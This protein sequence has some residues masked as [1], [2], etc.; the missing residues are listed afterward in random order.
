MTIVLYRKPGSKAV[1]SFWARGASGILR[2]VRWQLASLV[3][4]VACTPRPANPLAP[5][6][7]S[8]LEDS[9]ETP[10]PS[11]PAGAP[12]KQ[13][14]APVTLAEHAGLRLV[15][16]RRGRDFAVAPGRVIVLGE[17]LMELEALDPTTGESQWRTRVQDKSNGRRTLHLQ[18]EQLILH[19]G[20]T[21]IH[22]A[23]ASGRVLGSY[24]ATFNGNDLGCALRVYEGAVLADWG[25]WLAPSRAG[26]ACV[27]TCECE[28][29]LFDCVAG[30][31]IGSPYRATELHLHDDMG[32]AYN[33][34][35]MLRSE[36]VLRAAAVMIVR[37]EDDRQPTYLGLDPVTG[38]RLW[39]RSDLGAA[40]SQ[41][42][43][44]AGTDPDGRLCWLGD[45][46]RFVMFDCA[47]GTTRWQASTGDAKV[48]GQDA[49]LWHAGDV[50]LR[51][52]DDRRATIELREAKGGKRRWQ[53]SFAADRTPLLVGEPPPELFKD[54]FGAYLVLDPASGAT[55]GEISLLAGQTLHAAP[56]G[57]YL[58]IGAGQLAEFDPRGKL[59]RERPLAA[60]SSGAT[61][62]EFS[63]T[64]HHLIERTR[65]RT[66]LLRRDSLQPVLNLEGLWSVRPSQAALGPE[67]VA[68]IEHRGQEPG[69]ILVL[70]PAS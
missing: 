61:D 30:T 40:L 10:G 43:T 35:C 4:L 28:L 23:L 57:G 2:G 45:G 18:R 54:E 64:T 53:R 26:S 20:P 3:V 7:R 55:L 50:M 6:Q 42:S 31:A 38:A 19:A 46:A 36:P 39:A 59:L 48:Y 14:H 60:D 47:A 69:R 25:A 27:D 68:L 1:A 5:A 44:I 21:R 65:T 70:Q 12:A 58:R 24:P 13:A 22:V 17:D 34:M 51:H 66:R 56:E 15:L 52:H 32:S 67:A 63:V 29:Q 37:V 62:T 8:V 11:P 49:A 33:T 41:Y 9:S 16:E